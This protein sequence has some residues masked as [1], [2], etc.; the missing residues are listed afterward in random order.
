MTQTE[1]AATNKSDVMC[2]LK[3]LMNF[4]WE[5]LREKL[6]EFVIALENDD[7]KRALPLW[8]EFEARLRHRFGLERW[9]QQICVRADL[10][11]L[12]LWMA[13]QQSLH[14]TLLQLSARLDLNLL[15]SE[16]VRAFSRL[17][18]SY[19]HQ[20]R[21]VLAWA[22]KHISEDARGHLVEA[23]RDPLGDSQNDSDQFRVC[24]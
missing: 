21:S 4:D 16:Q 24:G 14:R 7:R 9:L 19:G 5:R 15:R 18:K 3:S 6:D 17:L 23:L 8:H 1:S 10:P 22:E 13:K 12:D 11:D 20:E 2:P